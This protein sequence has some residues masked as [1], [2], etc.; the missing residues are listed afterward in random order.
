MLS[1]IPVGNI[2]KQI[3]RDLFSI[4]ILGLSR[5]TKCSFSISV[6]AMYNRTITFDAAV[7][8]IQYF[9]FDGSKVLTNRSISAEKF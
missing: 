6:A 2:E 8:M 5:K 7:K 9:N 1:L 4:K 3:F